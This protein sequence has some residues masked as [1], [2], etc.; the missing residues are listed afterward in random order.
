MKN[1]ILFVLIGLGFQS[2]T[3]G[4][5][6]LVADDGTIIELTD[7]MNVSKK[8]KSNANVSNDD[9]YYS[10]SDPETV[11]ET[12]E[13]RSY[14]QTPAPTQERVLYVQAPARTQERVVYIERSQPIRT[15]PP[16]GYNNYSYHRGNYWYNQCNRYYGANTWGYNRNYRYG[17]YYL[18]S[19]QWHH[20]QRYYRQRYPN[21]NYGQ[22]NSYLSQNLRVVGST[23][24]F[25]GVVLR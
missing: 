11:T 4:R 3:T 16:I 5:Y 13:H 25:M 15:N 14:A 22:F 9:V 20:A 10:Q 17:N 1:F 23:L 7:D 21:S 12:T 18:N 19:Y 24:Y 2:C 6:V 8:K